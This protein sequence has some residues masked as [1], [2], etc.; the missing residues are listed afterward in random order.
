MQKYRESTKGD[1]AA[2]VAGGEGGAGAAGGGEFLDEAGAAVA[3]A[4]GET[5]LKKNSYTTIVG[6][7]QVRMRATINDTIIVNYNGTL[8]VV[9]P[10]S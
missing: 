7:V 6:L 5:G 2:G 10:S 3:A 4:F 9:S 8:K 1:K